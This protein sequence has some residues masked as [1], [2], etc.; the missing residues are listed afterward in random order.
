MNP[1]SGLRFVISLI[2][3][4]FLLAACGGADDTASDDAS[5]GGDASAV[6]ETFK[7]GM[8]LVGPKND[9]GW[10]QAHYEG[11]LFIEE[12][13]PNSEM[14]LFEL[15][16]PAD[17]PEATM[18]GIV[19]DMQ[20]EGVKLIFTT[21]DEFEEDTTKVA[22]DFPDIVFINVSGDDALTGEA[23]SNLGNIMGRMED[24]KA[25]AGCAA[26]LT[27]QTGSIGYMGPLV[28]HETLR[29]ASSAYL[30]ARYCYENYRGMSPGDLEFNVSWI[31]FWFHI[32]GVTSDPTEVANL[33]FDTGVDVIMSG[34]DTTEGIDV[35]GQRAD[36]GEAIWSVPYD[37]ENACDSKP[38]ICLGVPYFNWGPSYLATA[39][40][41]QDG[42]WV[43]SWQW[44]PPYWADLTDNNKTAAGWV[45][46]PALSAEAQDSLSLFI[47][48]LAGD[49]IDLWAGPLNLQDGTA[50][51]TA[52]STASDNDVWYLPQL[53]EGMIGSSE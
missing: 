21:S 31:G 44:N 51:V 48:G 9:H 18:E 22:A 4:A 35:A 43:Q 33:F 40:S 10:S 37:F 6:E 46:G 24:M 1:K 38:E 23:P 12:N 53:L 49:T 3:M 50:Y 15:F 19:S 8:I 13:L 39:I 26:A 29:L 42:S 30:G 11:G 7:F 45:N 52:G 27:T 32:P 47:V 20:T 5:T 28:N 17:K 41:V 16:N 2:L 25:I 14:V 36:A 34:I